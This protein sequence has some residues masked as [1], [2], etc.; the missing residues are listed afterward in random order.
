MPRATITKALQDS[1]FYGAV[2]FFLVMAAF[3]FYWMV[4][5]TFKT[6]GDHYK[7]THNPFWFNDPPTL[8]HFR[9][10]NEKT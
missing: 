5:T 8:Q 1:S 7:V 2:A 3:P 10:L 9:Y 4:I 6:N